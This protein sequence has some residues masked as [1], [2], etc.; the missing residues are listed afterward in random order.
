[1]NVQS[2]SQIINSYLTEPQASLLNGI[3]FG[4]DLKSTKYFYQQLRT[5]GLLHLVVLSGMNISLLSALICQFTAKFGKYIS[6][7]INIFLIILFVL[8]VG[9][10]A[11]V[12]RAAL[13]SIFTSVAIVFGKKYINL[14]SLLFSLVF[15]MLFFPQWIST[16]SL[17]LSY[18]ATIGLLLF[19]KKSPENPILKEIKTSMSAQLFTMPIIFWYFKEICLISLLSNLLVGWTI[20]PLMVLGLLT[21]FLGK[22][23]Y[24]LGF[25]P[26]QLAFGL[27]TYIVFIVEQLA[28]IPFALIKL[29]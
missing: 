16:I 12:V 20:A 21:I 13:T 3:I 28:K 7:V 25:I 8:F 22:I 26:A 2:F 14:L 17:Q 11:P 9:L 29:Q 24:W 6:L 27:L 4:I 23:H 18:A 19:N 1:M 5:V 10:Q 15:I